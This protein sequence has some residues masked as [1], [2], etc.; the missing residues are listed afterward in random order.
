MK[1]CMVML[2][3]IASIAGLGA[4]GGSPAGSAHPEPA[5]N[6]AAEWASIVQP[7]I[8]RASAPRSPASSFV[9]H[10][11]A[12]LAVYDAV[13]AI[14]G[15]HQPYHRAIEAPAGADV[16]AAVATAAYRTVRGRATPSQLA[17]LDERYNAYLKGIPDGQAK[18]DGIAIGESA[19]AGI[20]ALRAHDGFTNTVPYRCSASPPAAGEFE[21]NDGCGTEPVDAAFAR[22]TPFTFPDPSQFRPDDPDPFSSDQWVK[23]FNE[24]KTYGRVDSS[25]RTTEQTDVVYFWAEHPYVHWNRNLINLAVSRDLGTSDT[26]RL[27]AMAYTATSDAAIAGLEAKYF[28]RVWRPRTAIPRAAE[29]GNPRPILIQPG[30]RSSRSII[31]SAPRGTPLPQPPSPR[32]SQ[33]SSAPTRWS[34]P[35]RRART[36]FPNSCR[37]SG[38][39]PT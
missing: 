19:A 26:A 6:A 1:R 18:T 28:Y 24:V 20:L 27:F 33:R 12:Q 34:G 4:C 29:D 23:D 5:R 13:I 36:P 37:P 8:H 17:Y 31:R 15:G 7:A 22:V 35:S 25:V 32:R 2:A 14:E 16:R 38:P 30:L 10:T 39:I 21:P 9:L 11:M 3:L